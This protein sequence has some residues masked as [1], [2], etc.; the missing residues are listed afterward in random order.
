MSAEQMQSATRASQ[1][2]RLDQRTA[3]GRE[4]VRCCGGHTGVVMKGAQRKPMQ[5]TFVRTGER[6]YSV[7]A[8]VE[9]RPD[10]Y[11][12]PAPGYDPLMPHDLQHFIVER[13]LAIN[14]G[15]FGQL[16]A[17]G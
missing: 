10:T 7:R 13:A 1:K 5:I 15:V 6:R 12:S 17:G 16:A 11:M 2:V 14:G 9:C 3:R 8:T 4:L